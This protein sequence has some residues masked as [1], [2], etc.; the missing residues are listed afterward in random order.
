MSYQDI[1][2]YGVIGDMRTAAL[3]VQPGGEIP[4]KTSLKTPDCI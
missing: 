4:R 3:P 2:R 1:E